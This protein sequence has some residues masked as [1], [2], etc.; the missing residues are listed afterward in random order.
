MIETKQLQANK[1]KDQLQAIIKNSTF[2]E[3]YIL[4]EFKRFE[5]VY[6]KLI[7]E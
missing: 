2:L 5:T 1:D 4:F 6:M 3:I 7:V